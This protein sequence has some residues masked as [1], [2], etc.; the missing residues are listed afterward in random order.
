[1]APYGLV[2]VP[3]YLASKEALRIKYLLT[4]ASEQREWLYRSGVGVL[5]IVMEWLKTTD[6]SSVVF[7]LQKYL[8]FCK[9]NRNAS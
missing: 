3:H 9:L 2:A 1:M 6:L 8:I 4:M 5:S 7:C